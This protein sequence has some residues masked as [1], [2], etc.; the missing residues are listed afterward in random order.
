MLM[1]KVKLF[2]MTL[3]YRRMVCKKGKKNEIEMFVQEEVCR[4]FPGGCRD[5]ARR[6]AE[7]KHEAPIKIYQG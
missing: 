4:I 3:V 6:K 1:P 2:L 5:V 7:A